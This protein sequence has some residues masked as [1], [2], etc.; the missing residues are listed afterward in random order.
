M[1]A[2]IAIT[3]KRSVCPPSR[4][5]RRTTVSGR[6]K[7]AQVTAAIP[8]VTATPWG[9]K[10]RIFERVNPSVPPMKSNGKIGPASEPVTKDVLV[11]KAFTNTIRRS[12]PIPKAAGL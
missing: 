12:N 7:I 9:M 1:T 6:G 8:V 4:P 11:S 5:S 10:V 3:G 2:P